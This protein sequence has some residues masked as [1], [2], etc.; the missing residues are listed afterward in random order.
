[1]YSK[2][3]LAQKIALA[4]SLTTLVACNSSSNSSPDSSEPKGDMTAAP[5]AIEALTNNV[6]TKSTVATTEFTVSGLGEGVL[7]P[8]TFTACDTSCFA[9]VNDQ[10]VET[11][12]NGDVVTVRFLA[13]ELSL[14]TAAFTVD[15]GGQSASASVMT[16]PDLK[17]DD[18]PLIA[19][20]PEPVTGDKVVHIDSE[21]STEFRVYGVSPGQE[22]EIM[23][24][25][26]TGCTLSIDG[27]IQPEGKGVVS[28]NSLVTITLPT[29]SGYNQT[30]A[31]DV[32]IGSGDSAVE[33]KF[34][35]T[36]SR[37]TYMDPIAIESFDNLELLSDFVT[38]A[39]PVSG[40]DDAVGVSLVLSD[41]SYEQCQLVING[42]VQIEGAR[43]SVSNGDEV[44]VAIQTDINYGSVVSAR[45][46]SFG[47]QTSFSFKNRLDTDPDDVT[48][49]ATIDKADLETP[50]P[51]EPVTISGLGDGIIANINIDDCDSNCS[52]S[53]NGVTQ[54][55]DGS[56]T[57]KNGDEVIVTV[58]SATAP[59]TTENAVVAIGD[60][61]REAV[62]TAT[63]GVTTT[64]KVLFAEVDA[65]V[66][67]PPQVSATDSDQITLEGTLVEGSDST[68]PAFDSSNMEIHDAD[69]NKL[70]DVIYSGG[71]WSATVDVTQGVTNTYKLFIDKTTVTEVTPLM[72][73]VQGL[74]SVDD[75]FP[76]GMTLED[77]EISDL[78][79]QAA[80][81]DSDPILW[82]TSL[83]NQLVYS[84]P[85][86][87]AIENIEEPTQKLDILG[88][89]IRSVQVNNY[90]DTS[91]L[92]TTGYD[93]RIDATLM[94]DQSTTQPLVNNTVARYPAQTSI[95]ESGDRVYMTGSVDSKY[96]SMAVHIIWLAADGGF[97]Y[98]FVAD[99]KG[100]TYQ[101]G[102]TT[103]VQQTAFND[104]QS[105]DVY[106]VGDDASKKE[107]ALIL[108]KAAKSTARNIL[109]DTGDN[110]IWILKQ[111]DDYTQYDTDVVASNLMKQIM[112]EDA[113]G[114]P[115]SLNGGESIAVDDMNQTAYVV[116]SNEIYQFD[117]TN[118]L[119]G[120]HDINADDVTRVAVGTKLIDA[121]DTGDIGKFSAIVHEGDLSYLVVADGDD[122]KNDIYAVSKESGQRVFLLNAQ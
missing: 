60:L 74:T 1:M 20:I 79:V 94:G 89:D 24:A 47:V 31:V 115:I 64:D 69:G 72:V 53:V 16:L 84:Y 92:F 76:L 54:L 7:A 38:P 28:L 32:T 100:Q 27:V 96:S 59:K 119:D 44:A 45:L 75:V 67:F 2:R 95:P 90:I 49:V 21:Y 19:D 78:S 121:A 55:Q 52:L 103:R 101:A 25:N 36:T 112:L 85:L 34:E 108:T 56:A 11:V 35:L 77:N 111:V 51:S 120:A 50:V 29:A 33:K 80:N 18:F 97:S 99:S 23:L 43:S 6:A 105:V 98:D 66:T 14:A 13:S 82:F 42:V 113:A 116:T 106:S 65:A 68:L 57:V 26:C 122:G 10:P 4:L 30:T 87:G 88:Q 63:Y 46:S 8:I 37:D 117:L 62:Y 58:E 39:V 61:T 73:Q 9:L 107:Y 114:T 83:D 91:Y 118:V 12:Q 5:F 3:I 110:S 70:A 48:F 17:V 41:C 40:L 102:H 104:A 93:Q 86:V 15:I 109:P 22:V 81:E 71:L